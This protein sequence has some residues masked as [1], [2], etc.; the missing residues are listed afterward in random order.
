MKRIHT[1]ISLMVIFFAAVISIANSSGR[2][3]ARAGAPGDIGTCS[4]CHT[5]NGGT[6]S[7]EIVDAPSTIVAGTTYP[8]T[9]TLSDDNTSTQIGGF[10]LV[11]TDGVNNTQVGTFTPVDGAGTRVNPIDRLVQ[12]NPKDFSGG[13]VSW[14]VEWT[15]PESLS[16]DEIVF[17][18][19]GNAANDNNS[20]GAGDFTRTG[21]LSIPFSTEPSAIFGPTVE[22]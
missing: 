7:I 11:A 20:N 6:G 16:T 2:N 21:S 3:D 10:Q 15:A 18:F 9:L 17:F 12:S 1:F 8:L 19:V 22:R 13:Q 5:S 14:D 4:Q